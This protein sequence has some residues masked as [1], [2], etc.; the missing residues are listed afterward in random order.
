MN[1]SKS[2]HLPP[3]AGPMIES[4]RGLGY[5]T[6]TALADVIDNSITAGACNVEVFF[7]WRETRSTIAVLDDGSGMDEEE[8]SLAMR[9]GE[10]NP[11]DKRA[12]QDLGRFGLGLKTASFSQCRRLT[13]ASRKAGR[14]SCLRWDLDVL[15]AS[16]DDGW[17][18]LE[19]PAYGS[20]SLIAPLNLV[21]RGT[22]VLWEE[23]DRIVTLG[24]CKQDFLDLVDT[25]ERHLA[26]VFH[27]FLHGTQ[28][29][30]HLT[31]NG[32]SVQPWDP[33]L[34]RHTATWSS[35]LERIDADGGQVTVRCHVLPHKDRLDERDY[36]SAGGPDGWTAHQGFYVYRNE[37]LLVAGSWLGLGRGRS[38]TK[39]EA[40]RLARIRLD[41]HNTADADWKID[42]RKSTAKPP[43][44]I[45]ERLTRLAEDSRERARRVFAHRG[46]IVR[47]GSSEPLVQ[48]W[49]AE[50]FKGG[51][52]YRIETDHPAVRS[53]L[54]DAGLL[55]PQVRAMLR[56]LEETLPVQRIWLDTTEARETPR[57]GFTGEPPSAVCAIL[58]V[59]YR[60]MI[61]RKGLSPALAREQLLHTEPF[62][63]HPDLVASLPEEL[64]S[65][66]E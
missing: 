14:T 37:R 54:D 16:K 46:Q 19:G 35:P 7:S 58:S 63:N 27:R 53:V 30:L 10:R 57:T 13:V 18:L 32:R 65:G 44:S 38:W 15:A 12:A 23:L 41:I 26:M 6:A 47:T 60:N 33:F 42:V 66:E 43:V 29:Q 55:A 22:L 2:R 39:E 51:I 52:R 62:N 21:D 1:P 59:V 28:P 34:T 48:A 3:K 50:H 56:I 9:L 17:H 40:Y 20:E 11:R 36:N 45:R 5:S 8:L 64:A 61:L 31:I 49:R 4:L 24:F 25:V